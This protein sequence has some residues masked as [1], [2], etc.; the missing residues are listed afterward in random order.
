M[1]IEYCY[2]LSNHERLRAMLN[3]NVGTIVTTYKYEIIGIIG[4]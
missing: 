3:Y 1:N 2:F 4:T